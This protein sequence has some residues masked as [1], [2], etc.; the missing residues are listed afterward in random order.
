MDLNNSINCSFE[1][2]ALKKKRIRKKLTVYRCSLSV[3]MHNLDLK[4]MR[5]F[6]LH[7]TTSVGVDGEK[8][9]TLDQQEDHRIHW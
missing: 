2:S 1:K 3:T 6:E 5:N 4:L 7:F 8:N 9:K